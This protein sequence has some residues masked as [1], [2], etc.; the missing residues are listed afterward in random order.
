MALRVRFLQG[1]GTIR[2]Q[3]AHPNAAG[4]AV[5]SLT[6]KTLDQ[7]RVDHEL[8]SCLVCG[9]P[10]PKPYPRVP[11]IMGP[12]WD[13]DFDVRL[14]GY[15]NI[16]NVAF[17]NWQ[18]QDSCG[19]RNF[20]IS[21]NPSAGDLRH[22]ATYPTGLSNV[23]ANAVYHVPPSETSKV[24]FDDCV[25]FVCTGLNNTVLV[26]VDGSLTGHSEGASLLPLDPNLVIG[27]DRAMHSLT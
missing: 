25:D 18:Q 17:V 3:H 10:K 13:V 23:D 4:V 24:T 16:T 20:A 1:V 7:K 5:D 9:T 19:C 26:D 21:P 8:A 2:A 27:D 15:T 6:M 22:W 14:G 12:W 11:P